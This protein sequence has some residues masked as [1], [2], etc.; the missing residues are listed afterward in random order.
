MLACEAILGTP[1]SGPSV[2]TRVYAHDGKGL[3]RPFNVANQPSYFLPALEGGILV[4]R[5]GS[6]FED[7]TE[8]V[9]FELVRYLAHNNGGLATPLWYDEGSRAS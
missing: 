5:T 4:L 6:G 7:A 8:S 3:E 9:R 2:R 1:L